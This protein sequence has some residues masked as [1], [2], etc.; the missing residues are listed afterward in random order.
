MTHLRSLTRS[1]FTW[2]ALVLGLGL[3]QTG[4]SGSAEEESP[5]PSAS[6][7]PEVTPTP[8]PVPARCGEGLKELDGACVADIP[9]EWTQIIPGGDT[10]C[11]RGTEFSYFVRG[12]TVNKLVIGF[13]GGGACWDALSC[14]KANPTFS[15]A[16]TEGDNPNTL[17]DGVLDYNDPDNPF[18]DWY[19]V[20]IPYCTGDIHWGDNVATYYDDE[21]N[22]NVIHHK[23]FI[24]G[25]AVMK[26]IYEHFEAPETIF[27]T[28]VSAGA[29]GSIAFAPYVMEQYQQ[30]DVIQVGDCGAGV[31]TQEFLATGITNWDAQKNFPLEEIREADLIELQLNDVYIAVAEAYPYQLVGQYNTAN[32][33]NQRYYYEL[34]SGDTAGWSALMFESMDI[35]A[36]AVPNF[37]YYVA[38]GERHGILPYEE[39]YTYTVGDVSVRDWF[40]DI[41]SGVDVKNTKCSSCAEPE[42]FRLPA[43]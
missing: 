30:S 5:T 7:T 9:A 23:G 29:Y 6:A 3:V 12:G 28:G 37:R 11:S 34:M 14:S 26:W 15:E 38:G 2:T 42:T 19:A 40:A 33:W 21:G 1:T 4:C 27:M 24:N 8:S 32:D 41:V 35:I 16:V 43:N 31:V 10:I 36:E 18:K 17:T 13:D 20:I 39:F 25:Q 22:A